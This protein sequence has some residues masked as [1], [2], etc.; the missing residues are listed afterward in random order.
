MKHMISWEKNDSLTVVMFERQTQTIFKNKQQQMAM[1]RIPE[2]KI[3]Y[4][5]LYR[6]ILMVVVAWIRTL[7]VL[8]LQQHTGWYSDSF[9]VTRCVQSRV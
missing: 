4:S 7:L 6:S 8:S 1:L 5:L 2:K 3:E 9:L